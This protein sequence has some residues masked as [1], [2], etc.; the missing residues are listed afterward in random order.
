MTPKEGTQLLIGWLSLLR[1]IDNISLD[2]DLAPD[3]IAERLDRRQRAI[4][5]IQQLDA[6]LRELALSRANRW[7]DDSPPELQEI[8]AL[9]REGRDI[10]AR[11]S[12][13]DAKLI[14]IAEEKRHDLLER[15]RRSTLTKGYRPASLRPKIRPPVILDGRA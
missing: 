7:R 10:L 11:V 3:E 13:R 15:L 4:S 14:E 1:E 2:C 12:Q 8:E 5:G 9:L 6:Q